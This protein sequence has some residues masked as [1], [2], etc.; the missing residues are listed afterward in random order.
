MIDPNPGNGDP[1]SDS[2]TA[3]NSTGAG[4][5]NV[6]GSPEPATVAGGAAVSFGGAAGCPPIDYATYGTGETISFRDDILP[7]LGL[8]CVASDCHGAYEASPKAG[9]NLG[10]KCAYDINAKWLCTFPT[11]PDPDKTKPQPDL[12]IAND[13]Y[14]SL[15]E[16]ST[17]D[18]GEMVVR[19]KAGDPAN[20]FLVLKLADQQNS[21]GY[22]CTNQDA[23]HESNPP[24]CG[25]S[26]PQ[27][28]DLYCQGSYRPRFDA[29]ARWIANGAP[30]N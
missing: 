2:G 5:A 12:P 9:L 23:S 18:Y 21:K 6:N 10:Y 26:M 28:Q 13:V 4:G 30:N 22:A 27:N 3:P 25:V 11:V 8:S 16:L 1:V 14:A 19:V 15:M 20:S 7:M 17:T 29:I 24:P